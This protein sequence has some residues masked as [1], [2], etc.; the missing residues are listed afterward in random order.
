MAQKLKD[1]R[2]TNNGKKKSMDVA[3]I[4]NS[5][6]ANADNDD[7]AIALANAK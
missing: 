4:K 1:E 6:G 7:G 5:A 3:N 2:L